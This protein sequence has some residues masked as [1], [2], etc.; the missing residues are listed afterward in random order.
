MRKPN[1]HQQR[2]ARLLWQTILRDGQP[3]SERIRETVRALSQNPVRNTEAVLHCFAQRLDAHIRAHQVRVVS[4][5]PLTADQQQQV[6]GYFP[7]TDKLGSEVQ[8][9]TDPSLLGGLRVENGYRVVDQT[10]ARQI[11]ILKSILLK[12]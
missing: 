5:D 9:S 1:R 4:A 8:F 12:Q 2:E 7:E 3:D 6:A 11:E 10:V